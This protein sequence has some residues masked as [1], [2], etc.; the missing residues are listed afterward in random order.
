MRKVNWKI[1]IFT[2]KLADYIKLKIFSIKL[3]ANIETRGEDLGQG[4][5]LNKDRNQVK[6][7]GKP[8]RCHK[9]GKEIR[10]NKMSKLTASRMEIEMSRK[11]KPR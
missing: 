9:N 5:L 10:I 3:T 7:L 1:K 11:L 2:I 4:H 6:K 8:K